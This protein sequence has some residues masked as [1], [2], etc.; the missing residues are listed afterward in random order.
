MPLWTW[1]I[2]FAFEGKLGLANRTACVIFGKET[3]VGIFLHQVVN[4]IL[5]SM[6]SSADL[7]PC[8]KLF[9]GRWASSTSSRKDS[10][11]KNMWMGFMSLA[12]RLTVCTQ[13]GWRNDQ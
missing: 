2:P 12:G 3:A 8:S 11:L 9:P 4:A 1:T 10:L 5:S 7:V 6:K 13:S